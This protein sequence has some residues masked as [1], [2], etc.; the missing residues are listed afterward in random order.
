MRVFLSWSG[1]RSKGV[2]MALRDWM[3]KVFQTIDPWMSEKDIP[4][5]ARWSDSVAAHLKDAK[6]GIVCLTPENKTAPWINFEA[7]AISKSVDDAFVVP[8]L[9]GLEPTDLVGPMAQF[10]SRKSDH[11]GTKQLMDALRCHPSMASKPTDADFEESFQVWWPKLQKSLAAIPNAEQHAQLQR[12]EKEIATETLEIVR[13]LARTVGTVANQIPA[14]M[15]PILNP[16]NAFPHLRHAALQTAQLRTDPVKTLFQEDPSIP[17]FLGGE[18]NARAVV[19]ELQAGRYEHAVTMARAFTQGGSG[20]CSGAESDGVE[21]FTTCVQDKLF[22]I[23]SRIQN[24]L[25]KEGL[26]KGSG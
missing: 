3:R 22:D 1:Q 6:F 10:Q 21:E 7:G 12:T 5:G 17:E 23:L 26:T 9:F 15:N 25:K 11:D 14:L 16:Y 18:N 13:G 20:S 2:A 19:R 8:Y 4:T 24:N